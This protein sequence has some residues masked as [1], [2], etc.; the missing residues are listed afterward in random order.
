[1]INKEC[2]GQTV[3]PWEDLTL[4]RLTRCYR[5]PWVN[6]VS[7][8][9][10]TNA[11][12]KAIVSLAKH[13]KSRPTILDI[14]CGNAFVS[15]LLT[16]EGGVKVIGIDPNEKQL[17]RTPYKHPNLHLISAT[18]EDAV[19]FFQDGD[20]DVVFNSWMPHGIDLAES[21]YALNP[22]AIIFV[23]DRWGQTGTNA[24][25]QSREGY[26]SLVEW[27]GLTNAELANVFDYLCKDLDRLHIGFRRRYY[28]VDEA[29]SHKNWERTFKIRLRELWIDAPRCNI[30][31]VRFRSDI[32]PPQLPLGLNGLNKY[33]WEDDLEYVLSNILLRPDDAKLP[34][35]PPAIVTGE[36]SS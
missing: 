13:A 25:Y 31:D 32:A 36:N 9:P 22:K 1:M 15:H 34:L 24:T 5:V 18:A 14:G 35:Y 3:I 23:R 12:I 10:P 30:F 29:T 28:S 16:Q 27:Y 4:F 2:S 6:P 7:Y 17:L 19:E 26:Y 33:P 20:I 21:I 8:W 11:D